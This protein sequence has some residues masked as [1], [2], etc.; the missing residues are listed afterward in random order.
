MT[1]S[2]GAHVALA[3]FAQCYGAK[4]GAGGWDPLSAAADAPIIA[5]TYHARSISDQET[6]L[7]IAGT[8]PT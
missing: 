3:Y 7:G 8:T 4:Q 5:V 1:L 2:L 6:G